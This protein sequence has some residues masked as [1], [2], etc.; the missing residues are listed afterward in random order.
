MTKRIDMRRSIL[1]G[2]LLS[3][4]LTA[5]AG[6]QSP[7]AARGVCDRELAPASLKSEQAK[8]KNRMVDCSCLTGFLVGRY[9]ESDAELIVRLL[10]AS[11]AESKER[12]EAI[13]T[14]YG[15]EAIGALMKRVG[16][17]AKMGRDADKACPM[18]A[19]R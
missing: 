7:E 2:L 15:N 11:T 13:R 17:F 16:A 6:A 18:I 19:S 12:L 3:T 9:G 4:L 14:Q 10:A 1:L 5:A 8:D